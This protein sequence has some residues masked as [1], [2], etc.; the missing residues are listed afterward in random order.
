MQSA[1]HFTICLSVHNQHI[2]FGALHPKRCLIPGN[3]VG[4]RKKNKKILTGEN[5]HK[6][7]KT[8]G[9]V[10]QTLGLQPA[11]LSFE[12]LTDGATH[13]QSQ[14][15]APTPLFTDIPTSSPPRQRGASWVTRSHIFCTFLQVKN[16]NN[17][18]LVPK[19]KHFVWY[20]FICTH[21]FRC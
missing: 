21:M 11:R 2:H 4:S 6:K 18:Y 19:T 7:W 16:I 1:L 9:S 3:V 15:R 20:I 5:H 13:S 17:F 14:L 10:Q 8:D 12:D